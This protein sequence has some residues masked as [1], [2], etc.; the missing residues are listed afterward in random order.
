MVIAVMCGVLVVGMWLQQ[1][2]LQV[3]LLQSMALSINDS[4]ISGR[5]EIANKRMRMTAEKDDG[6]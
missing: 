5:D 1:G 6:R 2:G 4:Q 3:S